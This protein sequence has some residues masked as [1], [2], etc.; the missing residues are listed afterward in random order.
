MLIDE[1]T[2]RRE[3]FREGVAITLADGQSWIFP[4]PFI[5]LRLDFGAS[6]DRPTFAT[7]AARPTYGPGYWELLEDFMRSEDNAEQ[8]DL[9]A[10]LS[11]YL[12]RQNYDL[13][14]DELGALLAYRGGDDDNAE[15]WQQIADVA[16]GRGPK[17]SPAI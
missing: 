16:Q 15:M 3:A 9:V 8:I 7:G 13:A 14:D 10:S 4:K 6:K 2:R 17:A 12:L 1:S 11:V 5:E